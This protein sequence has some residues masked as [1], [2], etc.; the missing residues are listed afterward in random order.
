[1]LGMTLSKADLSSRNHRTI[2]NTSKVQ[3]EDQKFSSFSASCG[4]PV[5]PRPKADLCACQK[6]EWRLRPQKVRL[7]QPPLLCSQIIT[8]T[9]HA[10][11]A[12]GLGSW[13]ISEDSPPHNVKYHSTPVKFCAW[14]DRN[15]RGAHHKASCFMNR[16]LETYRLASYF[17]CQKVRVFMYSDWPLSPLWVFPA[18][19]TDTHSALGLFLIYL[20]PFYNMS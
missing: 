7:L 19:F 15:H 4:T 5:A 18:A 3:K 8:Y 17:F 11:R 12:P 16:N 20:P 9:Y 6:Q 1:M 2:T 10:Q 13:A 14:Q